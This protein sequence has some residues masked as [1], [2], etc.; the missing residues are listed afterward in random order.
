MKQDRAPSPSRVNLCPEC[1][2]ECPATPLG[3]ARHRALHI[4]WMLDHDHPDA[5]TEAALSAWRAYA[6]ALEEDHAHIRGRYLDRIA[7]LEDS[8]EQLEYENHQ[9]LT[10]EIEP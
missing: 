3:V 5:R 7:D 8:V 1:A 9:L 6:K 10:H 4:Q 2:Q